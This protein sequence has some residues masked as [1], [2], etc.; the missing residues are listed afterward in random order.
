MV[1]QISMA[2]QD[3]KGDCEAD[4]ISSDGG[5]FNLAYVIDAPQQRQH[6]SILLLSA[7]QNQSSQ[8]NWI[9]HPPDEFCG[10]FT[11]GLMQ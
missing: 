7:L 4:I 2:L 9:F 10:F 8:P 1:E 3:C 5:A 6:N 11:V